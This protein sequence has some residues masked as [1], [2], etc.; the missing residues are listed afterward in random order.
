LL[1]EATPCGGP[2]FQ[3]VKLEVQEVPDA[4]LPDVVL[5][6]PIEEQRGEASLEDVLV[7]LDYV[8][9]VE[10]REIALG[11]KLLEDP[12]IERGLVPPGPAEEAQVIMARL[13]GVDGIPQE[14]LV[15]EMRLDKPI[16]LVLRLPYRH[17]CVVG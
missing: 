17:P 14:L 9:L 3:I 6:L 2:D 8:L 15:I 13:K 7:I 11:R 16:G 4:S 10:I 1:D 12:P 5:E